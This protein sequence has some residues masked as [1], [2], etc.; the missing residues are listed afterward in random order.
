MDS[1]GQQMSVLKGAPFSE[2][3]KSSRESPEKASCLS[4]PTRARSRRLNYHNL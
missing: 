1:L 4:K 3:R 2:I